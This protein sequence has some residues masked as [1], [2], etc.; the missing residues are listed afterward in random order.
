MSGKDNR[1]RKGCTTNG[2]QWAT[3]QAMWKQPT[4]F[5]LVG[6]SDA[7]WRRL[8]GCFPLGFWGTD[9]G[10]PRTNP[11]RVHQKI[12]RAGGRKHK[13]R[14]MRKKRKKWRRSLFPTASLTSGVFWGS[15]PHPHTFSVLL[16]LLFSLDSICSF[17]FSN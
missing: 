1:C 16:C 3:A 17:S 13:T 11:P 4:F 10:L 2:P 7:F 9:A 5:C 15:H 14:K 8:F 6:G 12:L